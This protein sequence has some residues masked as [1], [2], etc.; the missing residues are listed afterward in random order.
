M[1]GPARTLRVFSVL[2]FFFSFLCWPAVAS[3]QTRH[4]VVRHQEQHV[5]RVV[6]AES[7]RRDGR[8]GAEASVRSLML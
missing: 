7:R 6:S 2:P 3:A 4:P 8:A 5:S 1:T